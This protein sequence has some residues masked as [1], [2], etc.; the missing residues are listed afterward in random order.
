MCAIREM[1]TWVFAYA[2]TNYA[3]YLSVYWFWMT[4]LP[5][6]H[7]DANTLLKSGQFAVQRSSNGG[8]S[9]TP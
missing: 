6:T 7:R 3:R 1:L 9:N 8:Q 5:Q 2:R 4:L